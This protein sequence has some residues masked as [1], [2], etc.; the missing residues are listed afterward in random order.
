MAQYYHEARVD[1]NQLE[2]YREDAAVLEKIVVNLGE[3]HGSLDALEIYLNR[4]NSCC[5][6]CQVGLAKEAG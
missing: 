1:A 6:A 2:T 4:G 5:N 3:R